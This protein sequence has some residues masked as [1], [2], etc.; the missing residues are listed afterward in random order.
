MISNLRAKL[1]RG[2][3]KKRRRTSLRIRIISHLL[4]S[5]EQLRRRTEIS[6]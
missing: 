4:A 1:R 3:R 6:R 2:K 5:L